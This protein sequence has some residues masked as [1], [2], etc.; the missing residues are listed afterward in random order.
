MNVLKNKLTIQDLEFCEEFHFL[1]GP[2][3]PV[4]EA[5]SVHALNRIIGHA[6]F[7]NR[8]F[9]TVYYRGQNDLFSTLLPS[10]LRGSAN[11]ASS[12]S[13]VGAFVNS[14]IADEKLPRELKID[15]LGEKDAK[16]VVEGMLQ[17]YGIKTRF[18]DYVDNH[19]V[20]LWMGLHEYETIKQINSYARFN[21]RESNSSTYLYIILSGF[22]FSSSQRL[23]NGIYRDEKYVFVDLR[24]ALPSTFV[25]PHAQ[26]GLLVRK[27]F[28]SEADISDYDQCDSVIGIVK[29][30]THNATEWMGNGELL[31][32]ANLFPPPSHDNGY[33]LLLSR[34]DLFDV[35]HQITRYV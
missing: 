31:T 14:V 1:Y 2:T 24:Q 9:G 12:C 18:V 32:Q 7:N 23:M 22:P 20:A 15:A 21:K 34:T 13:K 3:I 4:F 17:H 10:A 25:R 5:H 27:V 8:E 28:S 35:N 30:S 6:K 11:P 33:D 19:W 16:E 26:H 29:V